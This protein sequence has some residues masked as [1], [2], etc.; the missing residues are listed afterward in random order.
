MKLT[1]KGLLIS[2]IPYSETSLIVRCFTQQHGLRA[3]LF[4]GARKKHGNTLMALAPI[5]FTYYQRSDSQLAK[6][7]E[8]QLF[9]TYRELPFHPVKSSIVF[10][11]VEMLQLVLHEGVKDEY[12]FDFLVEELQW[13][14]IATVYGNYPVYWMLELSRHLGFYPYLADAAGKYF[15]LEEGRFT[16]LEPRNHTYQKGPAVELLRDLLSHSKEEILAMGI[17]KESRKEL[18][19]LLFAYFKCHVPHFRGLKSIEVIESLWY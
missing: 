13:L 3:F 19:D 4:Q 1:E 12:L 10:F 18:M 14:D 16:L 8:T 2:R 15:D 17:G 9:Y 11:Q 5:E 7:T 6:M